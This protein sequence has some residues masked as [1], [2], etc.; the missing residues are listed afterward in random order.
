MNEIFNT[1]HHQ[2]LKTAT[3]PRRADTPSP[4]RELQAIEATPD[5]GKA[6]SVFP[7]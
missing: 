7:S 5:T 3:L 2:S 6:A 1:S 4:L